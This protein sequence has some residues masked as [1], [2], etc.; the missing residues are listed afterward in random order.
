MYT[1]KLENLILYIAQKTKNDKSFDEEK[2]KAILEPFGKWY[3]VLG[4]DAD[5]LKTII[6]T[7][8]PH[9]KREIEKAKKIDKEYKL[10]KITTIKKKRESS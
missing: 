8:P 2:L 10:I 4:V 5:K 7:L 1:E 9:V 3:D 6:K